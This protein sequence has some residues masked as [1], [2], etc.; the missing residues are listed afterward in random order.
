MFKK[1]IAI[2]LLVGLLLLAF[3][4]PVAAD[5]GGEEI[6]TF[7]TW[8][9]AASGPLVSIIVGVALSWIME[10][11]PKYSEWESK[12]KRLVYFGLCLV[13]PVGASCLRA[14]LGYVAWGFDPLIWHALWAGFAAGGAGTVVHTRK[15]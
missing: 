14:G 11:Y 5:V 7:D 3:A 12:K 10:W 9:K 6:P 8:L 15:L 2:V 13:V 4:A 1:I